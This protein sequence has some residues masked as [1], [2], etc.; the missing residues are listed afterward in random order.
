M[1]YYIIIYTFC[2]T[3]VGCNYLL[4]TMHHEVNAPKA[5]KAAIGVVGVP[6][7]TVTNNDQVLAGIKWTS[8]N[9]I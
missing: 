7:R 9:R 3:L 8:I 5:Y 6:N 1:L 2:T 4:L